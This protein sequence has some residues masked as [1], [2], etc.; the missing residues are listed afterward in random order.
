M[1]T[2]SVLMNFDHWTTLEA[3]SA[4]LIVLH[5]S[6]RVLDLQFLTLKNPIHNQCY[7][8]S[9]TVMKKVVLNGNIL[10]VGF[11]D[12]AT[13]SYEDFCLLEYSAL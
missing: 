13:G 7:I 2:E 1:N 5:T 12:V 3:V 11:T 9:G 6:G 4:E 10:Y 8:G